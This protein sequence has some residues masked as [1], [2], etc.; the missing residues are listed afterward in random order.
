MIKKIVSHLNPRHMDDFLA[1]VV[2]KVKYPEA[3]VEYVHPQRVPYEYLVDSEICLVDVGGK[4]EPSLKNY[5]H[6][7]NLEL[8][9]SFVLV[10]I[11][12]LNQKIHVKE[13]VEKQVV[14][15]VDLTD[16]YGV[17]KA[18]EMTGVP[19]NTDEDRMRKEILLIDL[20]KHGQVVG[21]IVFKTLLAFD[22]YSDWIKEFYQRLDEKGLL[23]EP[24]AILAR[25]EALFRERLARAQ[26]FQRGD[27]KILVSD[28]SLA[29]NHFRAFNELG[30]DIII[31]R[32][33]MNRK[34]VSIIKNTSSP[35]TAQI[36]LA[37]VF[38]LYPKI[39]IHSNGFIAVVNVSF[40]EIDIEKIY[41][42]FVSTH[43]VCGCIGKDEIIGHFL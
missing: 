19:L 40:E 17:K 26:V 36:D 41:M 14:Q 11:H 42:L 7:Q 10:L 29:P 39:F 2:L 31:E 38:D 37:K 1:I 23:D 3:E 22:K 9:S 33:S 32:N 6:H 27:L 25:E 16:K 20:S 34:H 5:D 43:T 21:E 12:E 35:K 15:F 30:V 18:S 13:L 24:R 8:P 4:F 28:E